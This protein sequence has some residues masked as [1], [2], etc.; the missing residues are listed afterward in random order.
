M[1]TTPKTIHVE[2]GSELARLLDEVTTPVLLEKDGVRYLLSRALEHAPKEDPF[3]GWD[4]ERFRQILRETAGAWS[5]ID[6]EAM[7][8][9]IYRGREEG[10]RPINRPR[11]I[12]WS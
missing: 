6:A 2:P 11:P 1:T 7:K 5:D 4:P 9:Y 3:A 12:N 10:T 8:E